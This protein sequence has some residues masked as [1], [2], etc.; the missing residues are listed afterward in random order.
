LTHNSS[1]NIFI[2]ISSHTNR[3]E[4]IDD[5]PHSSNLHHIH[6]L[7]ENII[8]Y[9]PEDRFKYNAHRP[10]EPTV[11]EDRHRVGLPAS[12]HSPP[13]CSNCNGS[14][15]EITHA[16]ATLH[17][18]TN[19]PLKCTFIHTHT[20]YIYIYIIKSFS[21]STLVLNNQ[22]TWW[23]AVRYF[24]IT[25]V[26]VSRASMVNLFATRRQTYVKISNNERS[27]TP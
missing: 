18:F 23:N 7:F 16:R 19:I 26:E 24:E 25:C 27:Q 4:S 13:L 8:P 11:L 12:Y 10:G 9:W 20:I 1:Q 6:K 17:A 5:R 3:N 14:G 15:D 21:I 2:H 22:D